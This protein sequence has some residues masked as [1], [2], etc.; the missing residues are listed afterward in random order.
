MSAIP[1]LPQPG[2]KVIQ[3][4]TS[5]APVVV[6]PSL[7]PCIVGACHEIHELL[8]SDGTLNSDILVGGPAIATAPLEEASYALMGTKTLKLR[9]NGGVEQTF[10]MPGLITASLTAQQVASAIN[11]ATPAPSGFAAFVYDDGA[12]P[13][14]NKYLELRTTATG[15]SQQIQ[16]TGGTLLVHGDGNQLGYGV[17][18]TYYGLGSYIQ[19]AVYLKQ[20]SFPDPRSNLEELD[21]DED[22]IRVFANLGTENREILQS[23][24]FL[25]RATGNGCAQDVD[26]ADGDQT[27]PFVDLY[28]DAGVTKANL[29]APPGAA[30]HTSSVVDYTADLLDINNKTLVIQLDGAGQQTVTFVGDPVVSEAVAGLFGPTFTGDFTLTVNGQTGI[31]VNVSAAPDL[32]TTPTTSLVDQIN[33]DAQVVALGVGNIAFASD[34]NGNVGTTHLGLLVG[35]IPTAPV[36]NTDIRVT[37]E[38]TN[39]LFTTANVLLGNVYIQNLRVGGAGPRAAVYGTGGQIDSVISPNAGPVSQLSTTDLLL[40]STTSGNESKIEISSDSTALTDLGLTAGSYT[41]APFVTRVGDYLWIDG[42]NR[43]MITEVHPGGSTGRVKLATE[44]SVGLYEAVGPSPPISITTSWFIV[45]KQLDTVPSAQYGSTVPTPDLFIDTNG[46]VRIKHDWL[47]DTAG[48]PIVTTAVSLYLM[49]N[50]LRLDVSG[51]SASPALVGFDDTNALEDALGPIS[52]DNPLAYGIFVAMQNAPG[53]RVYGIGVD[54][55]SADRPYG[56][57]EGFASAYDFLESQ[58]VYAIGTMSSALDVALSLQTHVNAMSEPD[59]KMERI[60]IFHLGVPERKNDTIAASGND[61]D[62]LAGGPPDFDTKLSTL[63]SELLGLGIDPNSIDVSDGVFIDLGA[64]AYNWNVTGSVTD[65]SKL[66]VNQTFSPGEN[67]DGFYEE[68]EAFPTN[69]VS[70]SFSI[71]VRGAPVANKGEEVETV[72]GRGQG[73]ADRRMWMMQLDTLRASIGGVDQEIPGFFM[74]AAKVGQVAGLNPALPMTNRPIAV[75]TG[76]KGT[77][78]RY[79]TRQ[80]NQMAAGGADLI[81]QAAEGAP[82]SSRMQVTTKMTS[83]AEREQSIVKAV[84]FVAKFY[85]T[86]LKVYIGSYNITQSFLDTLSS[87][88]EALSRWLVEEAKVVAGAQMSNLLQDADQPDMIVADVSLTVLYPANYIQVTLII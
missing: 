14:S 71:K 59:Q 4:F 78:D 23:E 42:V 57:L 25:R 29:L 85:R 47:R 63:A 75:F 77:N 36:A 33:A 40:E 65:G 52:K 50:A 73:F 22:S 69:I 28:T 38:T 18:Q 21:I 7:I 80:L 12:T 44:V 37:G 31:V 58:E 67:D 48:A 8:D 81:V 49:Y 62:S 55:V 27:T 2:V 53:V 87:V 19:D 1:E 11:G 74:N 3:E 61:G 70:G 5:A 43:G 9:V 60:G 26:D 39:D 15:Q 10:T 72:Y 82:L 54:D 16:I 84:D 83:I 13:T 41:G 34:A 35:G 17:G 32:D 20:A 51:S 64:D 76:V 88:L 56:T 66:E 46:D 6:V 79:S 30:S 68:T 24:S 86:S 45:S